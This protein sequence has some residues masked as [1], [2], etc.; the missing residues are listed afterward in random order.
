[1]K[2]LHSR[3]CAGAVL[4]RRSRGFGR[5]VPPERAGSAVDAAALRRR[6]VPPVARGDPFPARDGAFPVR[7]VLH[8]PPPQVRA[9]V[10][11]DA[12]A[13]AGAC[14]AS[15]PVRA[16]VFLRAVDWHALAAERY[17]LEFRVV[18]TEGLG[19][20]FGY[21]VRAWR[22][23]AGA[24][25]CS[26]GR[27]SAGSRTAAATSRI[28]RLRSARGKPLAPESRSSPEGSAHAVVTD[29]EVKDAEAE[30]VCGDA[31]ARPERVKG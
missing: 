5:V 26:G 16:G 1:M 29:R 20:A 14:A 3:G 18:Q 10:R 27:C 13:C 11:D 7:E 30:P 31:Q 17:G 21:F 9:G 24:I 22:I 23:P 28:R 2:R 12:L 19:C 25:A 6:M 15:A 8:H 4:R